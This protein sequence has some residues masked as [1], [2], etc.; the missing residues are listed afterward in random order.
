[1]SKIIH[2][3]MNDTTANHCQWHRNDEHQNVKKKKCL[4][5]TV[6]NALKFF[7][8]KERNYILNIQ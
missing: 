2:N 3:Y 6:K 1:M 7:L 8:L 4:K 5:Y